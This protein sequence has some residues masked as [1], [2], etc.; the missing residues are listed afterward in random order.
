MTL[1]Y[2]VYLLIYQVLFPILI[3]ILFMSVVTIA[4]R[5]PFRLLPARYAPMIAFGI[6]T[7]FAVLE[8]FKDISQHSTQLILAKVSAILGAVLSQPFLRWF[9]ASK[10]AP[11]QGVMSTRNS[12][13]ATCQSHI[14]SLWG[15]VQYQPKLQKLD[16]SNGFRLNECENCGTHWLEY[17]YDPNVSFSYQVKWTFGSA[18][19]RVLRK[20][21]GGKSLLQWHQLEIKKT[22]KNLSD[23]ELQ[24]IDLH[25][26]CSS[27]QDNP[28]DMATALPT[29]MEQMM[30]QKRA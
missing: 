18:R 1:S 13:C 27:Y 26:K 8:I 3:A 12:Q 10:W 5:S 23:D 30:G 22:W 6:I 16:S 28:I 29:Y 15:P 17:R 11:Q 19:W 24:V 20:A 14:R 7:V 9:M 4:S 21:E 2:I 25:R